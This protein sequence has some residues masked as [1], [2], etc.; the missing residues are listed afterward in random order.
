MPTRK[1]DRRGLLA[2]W[3]ATV[4]AGILPRRALAAAPLAFGYDVI[5]LAGALG[6]VAKATDTFKKAGA[7]VDFYTFDS[8]NF[9]RDA[10][11]SG[12]ID[13]GI[14]GSTPFIIGAAKG[15][16]EAVAMAF[17]ASKLVSLF[18]GAKSGINSVK[19]LRG[20]RVAVQLGTS[21]SWIFMNKFLPKYGLSVS[22]IHLVNILGR[23]MISAL[24]AGSI[25]AF[26]GG[27]PYISTA[28]VAGLGKPIA[29]FSGVDM[30][31]FVL[32]ANRSVVEQ[33]RQEVVAFLR[34]WLATM[35]LF[36]TEPAKVA[37]IVQAAMDAQG[38][39][40]SD[41]AANLMIRKLG[42][43]AEY[44]PGI[45]S[46]MEEQSKVLIK[47]HVIGTIPDWDKLLNHSLL[48]QAMVA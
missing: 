44:R 48:E 36:Q 1:I 27:E 37:Q 40:I 25:D 12:H 6:M 39:K 15:E 14:L 19:E 11:I 16:M 3:G 18:V 28:E 34:G 38:F 17:Y 5:S 8:G 47:K 4:A 22:D 43:T 46:Y 35:K 23:N 29:D 10:M 31:P 9:T 32:G 13:L 45:K 24:V 21:T 20:R 33:R 7:D 26:I 41:N 30:M 2:L 42:V